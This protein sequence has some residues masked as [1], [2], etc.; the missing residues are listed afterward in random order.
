M[1]S[2]LI[3]LLV[4]V[5]SGLLVSAQAMWGTVI[6]NDHAL[7]GSLG[8]V[9]LN[10]ISN[11]KMWIGAFIYIVATLL[12]FFLLS[13]I[14]FF[15]VQIAMTGLSIIFSTFLAAWLFHEKLAVFNYIGALI[16]I[17]GVA[18]VVQK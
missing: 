15:S 5:L 17:V 16:V 2:Y 1:T 13:K 6:K 7:K 10:L 18:F 9:A 14:R 8:N 4:P 3:Y 12:Y 11:P